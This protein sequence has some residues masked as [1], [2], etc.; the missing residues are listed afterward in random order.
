MIV[1]INNPILGVPFNVFEYDANQFETL[2][3]LNRYPVL[4]LFKNP[5]GTF[6]NSV[7]GKPKY[8]RILIRLK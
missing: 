7:N 3:G 1:K 2:E 6:S 5:K 4:G 8:F